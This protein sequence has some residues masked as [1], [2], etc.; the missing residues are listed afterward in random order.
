MLSHNAVSYVVCIRLL[1]A[2][3]RAHKQELAK[4][5]FCITEAVSGWLQ[6]E[7]AFI[8]GLGMMSQEQVNVD[9]VTGHLISDSTWTYKIPTAM[10]IPQ[11]LNI[12]FLKVGHKPV[13]GA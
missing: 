7:G 12:S 8:M 10:C 2:L 4:S 5:P 11:Q 1:R 6:V 3:Q 13:W 9:D